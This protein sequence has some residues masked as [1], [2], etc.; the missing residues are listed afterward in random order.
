MDETKQSRFSRTKSQTSRARELR[1]NIS[2]TEHK[3][4]PYLRKEQ[5]GVKF[6]RQHP[7]GPYFAD[8]FCAALN[9]SVE[10]DGDWHD[11]KSDSKRD[12]FF[13]ERGIQTLRFPVS[14]I[15]ENLDGVLQ[16]IELAIRE[17]KSTGN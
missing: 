10:I 5:F 2:K 9:L 13:A 17:L 12:A 7:V 3:L 8:Y 4:W 6:R 1:S 15:D 14:D 16:Q 11:E